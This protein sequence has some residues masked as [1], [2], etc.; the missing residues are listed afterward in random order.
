M[1]YYLVD[2]FLLLCVQT[3]VVWRLFVHIR[4]RFLGVNSVPLKFI[5]L[6]QITQFVC[7]LYIRD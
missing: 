1:S 6:D 5:G 4:I 2:S 7:I 3:F